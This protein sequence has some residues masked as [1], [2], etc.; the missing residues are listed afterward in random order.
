MLILNKCKDEL[1]LEAVVVVVAIWNVEVLPWFVNATQSHVGIDNDRRDIV[2]PSLFVQPFLDK[3][4]NSVPKRTA[5]L[6]SFRSVV[7]RIGYN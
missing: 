6:D 2:L 1:H 4:E 3:G 5:A 7:D